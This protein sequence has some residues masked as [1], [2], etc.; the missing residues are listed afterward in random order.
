M[1]NLYTPQEIADLLKIKKNTVYELIKRGE[2]KATKIGKQFRISQE[3]LNDYL[4]QPADI[5]PAPQNVSQTYSKVYHSAQSSSFTNISGDTR[6]STSGLSDL[7]LILCGQDQILDSLSSHIEASPLGGLT[8]RSYMG[9]YNALNAL[10]LRKVHVSTAHLWDEATNSYNLPFI[11]HLVPGTRCIVIHLV[12]RVEGFYI[13]KGNPKLFSG[14]DDLTRDDITFVSRERGSGARI[15]ADAHLYKRNIN[16][17]N[18]KGYGHE[19]MSHINSAAAVSSGIADVAIG[20]ENVLPQFPN[21]DFIPIQE[22][23][24]D[25]VFLEESLSLPSIMTMIS[26]I[27]SDNFKKEL[28]VMNGYNVEGLGE[29]LMGEIPF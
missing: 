26:I 27:R 23:S 14:F 2:I 25:L 29:V 11:S 1:D 6:H 20:I 7:G 8:F 19:V 13:L 18:I 5:T 12:K 17:L 4:K 22:E 28:S 15:L 21:L 16:P 24:L 9:S 3:N 10:Y